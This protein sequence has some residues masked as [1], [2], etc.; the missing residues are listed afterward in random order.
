MRSEEHRGIARICGALAAAL[1]AAQLATTAAATRGM[2]GLTPDAMEYGLVARGL[3]EHG[4]FAADLVVIHPGLAR[5]IRHAPE[6]HGLLQPFLTVPASWALGPGADAVRAPALV[7]AAG[8]V[9]ATHFLATRVAGAVAGLAA[10][11][12]VASSRDLMLWAALAS[13]DVVW[14]LAST[15][16]TAFFLI[17]SAPGRSAWLLAAGATAALGTLQKVTGVVLPV[18]FLFCWVAEPRSARVAPGHAVAALAGPSLLALGAHAARNLASRGA[19]GFSFSGIDWLA[20]TGAGEYFAYYEVPPRTGEVLAALGAE[21]AIASFAE[22]LGHIGRTLVDSPL[23][24]VLGPLAML[25]LAIRPE[26]AR[27]GRLAL[28]HL[29]LVVGLVA[30]GY[31]AE[32][33]YL[34]SVLPLS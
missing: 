30:V 31:H 24:G 17:G 8:L 12:L 32:P 21:R 25:A 18:A 11:A 4:S 10:A 33:R 34:A 26:S 7:G 3:A 20:K 22:Q 15:L 19:P 16:A 28:V 13:D 27:F 14:A 6:L 1:A 2:T 29:G 5:E 9:L 23:L